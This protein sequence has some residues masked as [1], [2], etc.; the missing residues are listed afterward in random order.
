MTDLKALGKRAVKAKYEMQMLD[1]KTKNEVLLKVAERLLADRKEILSANL[2]D[3]KKG[4]ANGMHPGLIDRLRL[5]DA[6]IE[7]MAEGLDRL[8]ICRTR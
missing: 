4:E 5:T 1:T 6:R 7:A 3:I 2:E 8:Q